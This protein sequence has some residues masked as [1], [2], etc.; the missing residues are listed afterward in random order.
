MRVLGLIS[1][2]SADGAD[3]AVADFQPAE[4]VLT[5]RP[6][7][8][9]TLPWPEALAERIAHVL[10]A[11]TATAADIC[12][13]D[14]DLGAAFGTFA[15]A[16]LEELDAGPVDLVAS[17]GQ[18]IHH[19][20]APDGTVYATL[21]IGQPA[22]IAERVGVPVVA[23]FRARDV[24][25][26]GQGAPLVSAFDHLLLAG[27]GEPVGLLN[28]G[29]IANL[30][31]VRPGQPT[32]AFDCGPANALLDAAIQQATGDSW[33][34]GGARTA[35]GR[36]DDA[37]LAVLLDDPFLAADPPKSTGKE[38]YHAGYLSAALNRAPVEEPDD[39]LATLAEAVAAAVAAD[40]ARLGLRQVW[41]SG[42]GV[43]NAGLMRALEGRLGSAGAALSTSDALGVPADHKE[44]YAFAL[45]G[46]LTWHG[47]P[48]SIPSCTGAAGTRVLG[49]I[50]PGAEPLRLPEPLPA[51]PS[52]L[53]LDRAA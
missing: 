17:H 40:V 16:A 5:L 14:R 8:H 11:R 44:A 18:T 43:H 23:D 50:V 49:T 41:V 45:L 30:T 24:A 33:D 39:L 6:T 51:W 36:V 34:A 7:G 13:L 38:R 31:A 35:R 10:A 28:L 46:W 37:L 47:L 42:G 19:D 15:A 32:I 52:R 48:G 9:T 53:R 25:A 22:E 2:T 20:V 29:G 3:V 12:R 1:G 21:Q 26:G 4:D 27:A